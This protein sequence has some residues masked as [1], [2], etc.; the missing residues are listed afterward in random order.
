MILDIL[1]FNAGP[2]HASGRGALRDSQ[3]LVALLSDLY[4]ADAIGGEI[5]D[6]FVEGRVRHRAVLASTTA[7]SPKS[8]LRRH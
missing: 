8:R 6:K 3:E 2:V 4:G 1:P 7:P 5:E